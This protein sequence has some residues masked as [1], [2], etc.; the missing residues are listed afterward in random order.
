MVKHKLHLLLAGL[1][2]APLALAQEAPAPSPTPKF[3]P[4]CTQSEI[5]AMKRNVESGEQEVNAVKEELNI[6]AETLNRKIDVVSEETKSGGGTYA[7]YKELAQQVDHTEGIVKGIKD[8][9]AAALKRIETKWESCKVPATALKVNKLDK[10]IERVSELLNQHIAIC[11]ETIK[12]AADARVTIANSGKQQPVLPWNV[13]PYTPPKD[14]SAP[15]R[16]SGS[17]YSPH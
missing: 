8:R 13:R 10:G 14:P 16:G 9:L 4:Y 15:R 7:T 11:D 3:R 6:E 5:D 17:R 1:L 2:C 12:Q